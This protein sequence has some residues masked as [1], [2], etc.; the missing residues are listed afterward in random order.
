MLPAALLFCAAGSAFAQDQQVG[1]RT[2][3][4]GGSY[5]AFEDDPI[6]V[7]LNPA[8]IATQPDAAS[9]AYQTYTIYEF[10]TPPNGQG[11]VGTNGE[12]SWN[13]PG[14]L[15]TYLGAVYQLGSEGNHAVGFCFTTP[16]RMKYLWESIQSTPV[17]IL[18]DQVFWRL[19]AA[20]ARDFRFQPEGFLTHVSVGVGLDVSITRWTHQEVKDLGGGNGAATITLT[21]T[22]M[23]FGGGAGLLVG[24]YDNTRNFK[25]N[26]GAAWQSQA[27]YNFTLSQSFTPLFDW[28]NQ[29][30]AGMTVYLFDGMP[31]RFTVDAQVIQWKKAGTPSQVAGSPDFQNTLNYSLGVEYRVKVAETTSLYPRL[32]LRRYDAPWGDKHNLPAVGNSILDIRTRDEKFLIFTFGAGVGWLT[33]ARKQRSFDLAG[34]VGGDAPGFAV[35]YTME[36]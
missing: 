30:Q 13:D 9:I 16:F 27:N 6:S 32:G 22:D 24:L 21:G 15:P 14:L 20:Y 2:K 17:P 8:G 18:E 29:Y 28:P 34:D 5:T 4:M 25:V 12:Y 3:A 10:Q 26:L 35:S 36:F 1:A 23:G 33:E 31:L 11:I 19:R 7:W